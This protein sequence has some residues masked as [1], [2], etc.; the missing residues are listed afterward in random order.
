MPEIRDISDHQRLGLLD[1]REFAAAEGL[2]SAR[3]CETLGTR[4]L[5]QELLGGNPCNILYTEHRKPYLEGRSEK[6]SVSHSH[7][8]LAVIMNAR[9]ETGVDIELIRDKVLR[10]RYKFLNEQENKFAGGD[11]EKLI[12]LWAAKESMYKAYGRKQLDFSAHMSVQPFSGNELR[13]SL[14]RG[15]VRHEFALRRERI[16]D[17][18]LVYILHEIPVAYGQ[19]L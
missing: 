5:V 6:I 15:D 7:D 4:F 11:V 17:Y 10:I 16:G 2:T 18:I 19:A 1:L 8:R 13:G 12:T 14:A 3:E 9:E